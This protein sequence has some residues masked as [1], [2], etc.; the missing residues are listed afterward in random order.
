MRA[1]IFWIAAFAVCFAAT[2]LVRR[3]AL[4]RGWLAVPKEDRW[5]VKPTALF[6]GIAIF[7]GLALP[8]AWVADPGTILAFAGAH[9]QP[10]PAPSVAAV[11]LAGALFLFVLGLLDDVLRLKPH[12]KLVG[13]ILAASLVVFLGYRL[14]WFS[15]LTVDTLVTLFWVVGVTNAFNLIDNMDGLCAGT[16]AIAA[17]VLACLYAG[18]AAEAAFCALA[19]SGA[20]TAFLVYNFKPASIFMGDCGSLV[21]GYA[22]AVLGLVY[23]QAAPVNAFSL[24]AVPVMVFMVPILDTTL[25]TLIRILSGR[26]ASTGGRDHT[27]HRLVLMGFSEKRAVLFLYGVGA[28]SGLSA[29]FVSRSDT[30]TSPVAIIPLAVSALLMGVYLAQ[31]RVYPEKEFSRLRDRAFTPILVDLTHKKQLALVLLDLFLISFSYYLSYRLRFD[32][33]VLPY[34][35]DGFLDSLPAVIACKFAAFFALGVYRGMWRYVGASDLFLFFKAS[36]LGSLLAVAAATFLYRF[37]NFSKGIFVIV[38]VITT[39]L[40]VGVRGS[41]RL[42]VDSVQRKT[43]SGD[44]S[45]FS[46]ACFLRS[47]RGS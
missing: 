31:I 16:G 34:Y 4:R 39:V 28:V 11:I 46:C 26:K 45:C 9:G 40:L 23:A 42:F 15:S 27:S 36:S 38:W 33:D 7:A 6:G 43:L 12:T 2:P 17:T 1:A 21:I 30:L 3:V 24:Y 44:T 47:S 8:L 41:F 20:L 14:H 35:F 37:E 18:T 10:R 5:H 22:L 32:Y 25:V 29:L 19:L 13:Q